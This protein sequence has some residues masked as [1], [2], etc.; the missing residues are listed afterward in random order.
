MQKI[1][2]IIIGGGPCG[3][4]AAIE[5]KK[6]GIETLVIEK[7]NVVESIYNYPTHQ[8]FFSSSDKLSIGDI[9]FIVE[10]SKPRR[11][12]ALVYYREVVKHHQLN[13]HAFE[14]VLTVKKMNNRFTITTTKDVYECKFLT[15]ATGYYGQHNTL[16][17]EGAELSKVF[18]YFKEAHPYFDQNVVVIGGKN[19][20]VDAALELEK[21]GANVTVIYRG[22]HYPKAIKP[23]ILPNFESLVNHEKITMEF[24]ANV[25]QITEENVTYEKD[26]KTI[27]IPNDYV[28]AMIGYHPNYEF[29]ESIGIEIN[30]NEYGT[31]PVY[32]RETYETNVENCYIAGV[33]AAGNDANTIFI[34]NGKYHGGLITQSI[35]T[36]KQTPLES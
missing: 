36:K 6:K 11:N 4:S 7:G 32:N 19:S 26:G 20:A 15:V 34:E 12:Q 30:T 35:L 9:P 28:F 22:D 18:H 25:T 29:L 17:V 8:T 5:Q 3:L 21:A 14:E 10:E 24:N 2:S 1:E 27:T 33:I 13:I 23:W 16:E 31:A